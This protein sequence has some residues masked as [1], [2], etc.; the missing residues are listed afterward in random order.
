M[1]KIYKLSFNSAAHYHEVVDQLQIDY[2]VEGITVQTG[3]TDEGEQIVSDR[4]HVDLIADEGLG[5]EQFIDPVIA[6]SNRYAHVFAGCDYPI[7]MP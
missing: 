5:L 1:K 4:Y 3:T 2:A 7:A 6:N